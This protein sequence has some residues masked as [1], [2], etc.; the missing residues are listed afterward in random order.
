MKIGPALLTYDHMN[1]RLRISK[2]V[3]G[4]SVVVDDRGGP[5]NR[6]SDE[7]GVVVIVLVVVVKRGWWWC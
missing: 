5:L 6:L 2:K 3:D 1:G 7:R 4:V